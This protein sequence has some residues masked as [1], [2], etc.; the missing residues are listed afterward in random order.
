MEVRNILLEETE[1]ET[2]GTD[3]VLYINEESQEFLE[4]ERIKTILEKFCR[5]LPVPIFFEGQTDQ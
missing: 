4:A 1:K 3:I 5:F 2:R